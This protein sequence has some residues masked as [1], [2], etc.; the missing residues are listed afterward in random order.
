MTAHKTYGDEIYVDCPWCSAPQC[1][2]DYHMDGCLEEGFVFECD[3]CKH[4]IEITGVYYAVSVTADRKPR[5]YAVCGACKGR[6][7]VTEKIRKA[8][9]IPICVACSVPG[10]YEESAE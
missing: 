1:I 6:T 3:D 8:A 5:V 7:L 9:P 10:K 2:K 4:V